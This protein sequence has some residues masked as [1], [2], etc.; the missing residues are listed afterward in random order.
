MTT[1]DRLKRSLLAAMFLVSASSIAVLLLAVVQNRD[2]IRGFGPT[3][4]AYDVLGSPLAPGWLACRDLF[5]RMSPSSILR[6]A[7]M[8]PLISVVADTGLIFGV[9]QLLAR[10]TARSAD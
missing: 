9:W 10:R 1:A 7:V 6:S 4:V 8:V 5:Q 3:E 2:E